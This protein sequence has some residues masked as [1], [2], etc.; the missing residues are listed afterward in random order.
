[1]PMLPAEISVYPS[2]LLDG[3]TSGCP[4]RRWWALF[5][6]AR[7]EKAVARQLLAREVPFY[8][9]LIPKDNVIRGR[10]FR[11]HIPLFADYVFQYGT[12]EDRLTA[13]TTNRVPRT[14]PVV[15]QLQLFKDLR[16]VKLAIEAD[17]PLAIERRLRPGQLV[18]IKSGPMQGME[19][20]VTARRGRI[21]LLIAVHF[22]Q[23]GVSVEIDDCMVESIG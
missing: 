20:V 15:D 22:L 18:R 2:D 17:R 14:I 11:S 12:D 7:Q 21:R 16:Q 9:P 4:E 13:L 10:R 6:K 23:S 8:L 1:M 19:G 5:T 3:F